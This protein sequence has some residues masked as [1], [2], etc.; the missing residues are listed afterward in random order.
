M[1]TPHRVHLESP[2]ASGAWS[3]DAQAIGAHFALIFGHNLETA[4]LLM[5]G[6]RYSPRGGVGAPDSAASAA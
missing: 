6:W 5:G 3:G 2:A 1:R 4:G